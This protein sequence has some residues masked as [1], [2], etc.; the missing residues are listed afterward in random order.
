MEWTQMIYL[1]CSLVVAE[2]CNSVKVEWA[3]WE[4]WEEE[5]VEAI[6]LFISNEK[7]IDSIMR[8]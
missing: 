2:V 4:E 5:V 3:A 1:K 6:S 8:L 7:I